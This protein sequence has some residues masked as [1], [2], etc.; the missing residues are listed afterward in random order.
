MPACAVLIAI[1]GYINF[2][3]ASHCLVSFLC[4]QTTY[5][6][7]RGTYQFSPD[8]FWIWTGYSLPQLQ[9]AGGRDRHQHHSNLQSNKQLK[10]RI[11]GQSLSA[12]WVTRTEQFANEITFIG[13]G[14]HA[15]WRGHVWFF[16]CAGIIRI[17]LWNIKAASKTK[18]AIAVVV[19]A[20]S[21]RCATRKSTYTA[22]FMCAWPV[23]NRLELPAGC[24]KTLWYI[25]IITIPLREETMTLAFAAVI[26]WFWFCECGVPI[27]I[28]WLA[29]AVSVNVIFWIAAILLIGHG[30]CRLRQSAPEMVVSDWLANAGKPRSGSGKLLIGSN[31]N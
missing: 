12:K 30:D 10:S 16:N 25:K 22:L 7:R 27:S 31:I 9:M 20:T 14:S 13:H 4:H 23:V 3:H 6:W 26:I 15:D 29:A 11:R 18:S 19:M 5:R 8:L 17:P 21:W 2:S 28:Y 1:L 24:F